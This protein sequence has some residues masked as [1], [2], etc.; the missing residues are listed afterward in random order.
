M[1][2]FEKETFELGLFLRNAFN[3]E[4]FIFP[5]VQSDPGKRP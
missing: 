2:I 5:A 3:G 4:A 1:N